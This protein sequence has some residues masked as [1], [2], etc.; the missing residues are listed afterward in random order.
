MSSEKKETIKIYL[1][2]RPAR[3][4]SKN[5]QIDKEFDSAK[6]K[7]HLDKNVHSEVINNQIED[8]S[9]Q[10]TDVFDR[11]TTQEQTFDR[12]AKGCVESVLQGY[13]STIFAY[14]QTGSGK[15][16]SITGGS[17]SY[18]QRGII[19]RSIAMIFDAVK[20]DPTVNTEIRVSYMQI[21]SDK[22][23]DLLNK[24][25]DAKCLEDLPRVTVAEGDEEFIVKG[26][27]QHKCDRQADALNL[28]FLGDTNRMYCET[29]MNNSSSRSHCIFTIMIQQQ[30][31]GSAI[32]RR[33]KLHLVDLAGSERV[34]KTGAEGR[35]LQEAR[36][37]N[38]SLHFLQEVITALCDKAEGK[39]DHIPYRQSL[40]T[41]VLR[42]S[43]GGNCKTVM[44]ATAHPQDLWM[45]ETI[46]TCKFAQ[47]VA[48]IKVNARVNEETDPTLL[49][50]KLRSEVATLKEEL[51]MYR[52][53]DQAGDR[54]LSTDEKDR[55]REALDR[56]LKNDN[57]EENLTGLEGDLARI[58]Y[59]FSV[60]KDTVNAKGG[61]LT[62]T[63]AV[64]SGTPK[65]NPSTPD[66]SPESGGV[67]GVNAK[68]YH[69]LQLQ[70]QY[71]DNELNMLLGIVQ[72]YQRRKRTL[73][74]QTG[75]DCDVSQSDHQNPRIPTPPSKPPSMTREDQHNQVKM[76]SVQH[77]L[78]SDYNLES[79]D[80]HGLELFK[81]TASAFE[82]FRR[83]WRKFEQVE[84][85]K[86]EQRT[87]CD[88]AKSLAATVC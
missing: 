11:E 18:D 8:Y 63:P 29:T 79:L 12:V 87:R 26:L 44:L 75:L 31:P 14:G 6:I 53:G 39:R 20:K 25:E 68:Q 2:V 34:K 37:I 16:F 3:D 50:K 65:T 9:F 47:R 22:G 28:L 69:Q 40:M 58:F 19:P 54:I 70:L 27:G 80:T 51:A 24:G 35:L 4:P 10:F 30:T 76:V 56:Y 23:Q 17:E 72:K 45:D 43:L 71:K 7:F 62:Q 88:R 52:K 78:A 85:Q 57:P 49:V 42:D 59:C 64:Q 74:T 36:Y 81:D 82:Q 41:M 86:D 15:T 38:L 77:Q 21:Y 13:N 48:S 84:R 61:A 67:E 46:S 33:S 32:V 83:S 1:R 60:L 66:V 5:Y 55:C 73:A